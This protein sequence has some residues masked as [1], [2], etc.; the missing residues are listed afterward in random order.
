[1]SDLTLKLAAVALSARRATW[2]YHQFFPSEWAGGDMNAEL[3]HMVIMRRING[4]PRDS[5]RD[6]LDMSQLYL[7]YGVAL[8]TPS[9]K[10]VLKQ[11][12]RVEKLRDWLT[13]QLGRYLAGRYGADEGRNRLVEGMRT[14][15]L[16][17]EALEIQ[18]RVGMV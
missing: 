6:P 12:H 7:L 13:H 8:L 17:R 2:E 14:I 16:A 15:S 18:E 1:M 10:V 5:G 11:A 9:T 4:W 3:R